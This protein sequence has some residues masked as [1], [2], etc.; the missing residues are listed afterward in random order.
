MYFHGVSKHRCSKGE[1]LESIVVFYHDIQYI[2]QSYNKIYFCKIK[3][4]KNNQ[5]FIAILLN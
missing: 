1:F 3:G 2:L 5:T 4:Y